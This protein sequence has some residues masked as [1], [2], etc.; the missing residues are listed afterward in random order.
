MVPMIQRAAPSSRCSEVHLEVV[1]ACDGNLGEE[2]ILGPLDCI[3]CTA[4]G[5]FF[6][7]GSTGTAQRIVR[8]EIRVFCS[9]SNSDR[10]RPRQWR[11]ESEANLGERCKNLPVILAFVED[12]AKLT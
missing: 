1:N 11:R 2:L 8:R 9:M 3:R 4:S 7:V 5:Y 6:L 10:N 12:K